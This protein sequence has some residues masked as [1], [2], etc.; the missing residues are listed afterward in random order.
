MNT[1]RLI[2][3]QKGSIAHY[4]GL[5][6]QSWGDI[7]RDFISLTFACHELG[8]CGSVPR[9]LLMLFDDDDC[10]ISAMAAAGLDYLCSLLTRHA[11]P[12]YEFTAWIIQGRK[13]WGWFPREG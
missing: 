9:G 2:I 8:L 10:D 1:C 5:L 12:G 11:A 7:S 4:R 6:L 13:V 3:T